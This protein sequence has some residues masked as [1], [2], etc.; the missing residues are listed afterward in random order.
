MS[1][2]V[3]TAGVILVQLRSVDLDSSTPER[4]SRFIGFVCVMVSIFT[5]G[6]SGVYFEYLVKFGSVEKTSVSLR[7]SQLGEPCS[8]E[9]SEV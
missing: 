7:N 9:S 6:I 3:L 5:S 1:L 2:V 8:F 4:G